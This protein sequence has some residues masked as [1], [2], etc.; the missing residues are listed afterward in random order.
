MA[1]LASLARDPYG[2]IA[3]VP[4][5]ASAL[6]RPG[7]G[8]GQ[9]KAELTLRQKSF[10]PMAVNKSIEMSGEAVEKQD[11]G[12]QQPEIVPPRQISAAKLT[13]STSTCCGIQ[14]SFASC[15]IHLQCQEPLGKLL[16]WDLDRLERW[17]HVNHMKFNKAKGKVLHMGQGNPK[18]NS[19]L[20]REWM[21]SSPEQKDLEVLVDKKLTMSRQCALAA[22]KATRVLGCVSSSWDRVHPQQVCQQHQAVWWV[23]T[24]EGRDAIQRDLDRLERWDHVN[25][26]E[27]N[28]AKGKVL[29]VGQGNPKHNSRLGREWME[30]SPEE[31]DLG[32]LGDEKLSITQQCAL[33]A[34]KATRVLGCVSSS[35]KLA[36]LGSSDGRAALQP[37]TPSPG[38]P[39]QQA[40]GPA[41]PEDPGLHVPGWTPH[42]HALSGPTPKTPEFLR[43]RQ[44]PVLPGDAGAPAAD[45]VPDAEGTIY[46]SIRY[47]SRT[48]KHP[49]D[50]GSAPEDSPS[51]PAGDKPSIPVPEVIIREEPGSEGSPVPV[52]ARVC[53]PPRVPQPWQPASPPEPQEETPPMLPEKHFDVA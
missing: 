36:Q 46:E 40:D 25:H 52:Y 29:H 4:T 21:E 19:R 20:G 38:E 5:V 51:L 53:K 11:R 49:R 44:L 6:P 42:S 43:H 8:D 33:A 12:E 32:L 27:F 17:D 10:R 18:H 39:R 37:G 48:M 31:K 34:Q 1:C 24:L 7:H 22:Q 9:D 15:P 14:A 3:H 47:K 41:V 30:S 26:M 2:A 13:L 16:P 50:A 45:C 23:N 28:K 35:V